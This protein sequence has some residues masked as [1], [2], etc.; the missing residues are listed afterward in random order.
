VLNTNIGAHLPSIFK[1]GV[2]GKK[3]PHFWLIEQG[4]IA[5]LP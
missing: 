5:I 2:T 4:A 3:R 1:T